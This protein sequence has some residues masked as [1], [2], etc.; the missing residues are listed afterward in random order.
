MSH[1]LNKQALIFLKNKFSTLKPQEKELLGVCLLKHKLG[2]AVDNE[3]KSIMSFFSPIE[4]PSESEK[5]DQLINYLYA[6]KNSLPEF[7]KSEESLTELKLLIQSTHSDLPKLNSTDEDP[8][9][10]DEKS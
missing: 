1:H 8:T 2:V 4:I 3:I 5:V 6:E 9:L 10:K 7:L